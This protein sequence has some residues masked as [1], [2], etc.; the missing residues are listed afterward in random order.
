[1]ISIKHNK[2]L[3]KQF[4]RQKESEF[5]TQLLATQPTLNLDYMRKEHYYDA[6][7]TYPLSYDAR[8]QFVIDT[9]K[10]KIIGIANDGR[11]VDLQLDFSV[12][13]TRHPASRY[14]RDVE[15]TIDD[16]DKAINSQPLLS[17][18]RLQITCL[19]SFKKRLND[20]QVY[21]F[22]TAH[23]HFKD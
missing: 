4:I 16:F 11:Q 2:K 22:E 23:D 15:I 6:T 20:Q 13:L 5:A 7:I 18:P 3:V 21:R 14:Q 12:Q 17:C 8:E 1:M 10:I 9:D 19:R